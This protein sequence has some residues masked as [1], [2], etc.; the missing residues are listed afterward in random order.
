MDQ[1]LIPGNNLIDQKDIRKTFVT[2]GK[3]W[4]WFVIFI[5]LGIGASIVYLYKATNYYG[6]TCE[7]LVKTPSDPFKDALSEALP[8]PPKK[9]D[10]AN[11]TKILRSTRLIEETVNKLN[12]DISYFIKGRLKTGEVYKQV[13]FSVDGKVSDRSLY[14][15]YF[16][17]NI[18]DKNRFKVEV[19]INEKPFSKVARFGEPVIHPAFSFILSSDS[20]VIERNPRIAEVNYSF[21]FNERRALIKKYQTALLVEKADAASVI[22]ASIEDEVPEK[23]VDFLNTLTGL[24]IENSV[25]VNVKVNE[26][27]LSFIE[28]QL[29]EVEGQL[30][31]VE[32]NLEQFQREKTT[33]NIGEE[34]N[35]LFQRAM[36]FDSEKAR[37]TIQLRSIDQ[38]YEYLT[39][40]GGD[41]L[42]ISP[43]I[44]AE[45]S[46]NALATSFNELFALQQKRTNLLFSNTPSSPL[47]R[48]VDIQVVNLKANMQGIVL[49][50]RKTLVNKINSLSSQVGEY[51]AVL[52]TMPTT[53]RGLVN[54]NR[55][56]EIYSQ[57][58]KFLLET[59]A[60]T[61]IAKA[62]I[63]ADKSV[64]EPAY[65]TGLIRPLKLK[66][67]FTGI[68]G[69]L[70]LALMLIFMKGVFLNYIQTKDDLRDITNLPII[71]VIGKTKEADEG[72]L[73]VD[74]YP[75]SQTSEAFR[76]IRTNLAYFAAKVQSKVILIT[77][78]VAGEGKTFCAVNTA[79]ILAKAKKK[80]VLIDLDLHKP[81][82]ANAFNLTNEIGVTSYIVGKASLNEIIKDT[83]IENLQVILT[84]PR[85]PNA[86]ELILDPMMEQLI[87]ELKSIYEFI[88][89]DTPPV[90]LLS[91]ALVLMKHADLNMYVLKAG[92][93]KKDFVDIAHQIVEKNEV[94]HLTFILNSVNNKNIPAGYGGGY[95]A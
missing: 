55:N 41:N 66:T 83:G 62:G 61:I 20:L 73:V 52:R 3:N 60:Q 26:N 5:T 36:D 12:L 31:N 87:K 93:S 4:Y 45:T 68:G 28:G 37:L 67:I 42:A 59:R 47:V 7:I 51:Q 46:D 8:T 49:N 78:S 63:V 34:G 1:K 50:L 84:G 48:E 64:L 15:T 16:N 75:K 86:S 33:I 30:N 6:A 95:Y 56:V 38:M 43:S 81:K 88:I 94:K 72:Y 25:A 32:G 85:T 14:N 80:V 74:K 79:I 92:Y 21:T 70:A 53:Q 44:L 2:I 13:P 24:Y 69:G 91:D 57:I 17:I 27:T 54:I 22:I 18:L 11:E 76:V 65:T 90:G 89:I 39:S 77:S 9:E 82:Q 23:A 71:G 10:I 40:S 29:R 19:T 35:M 58:Y